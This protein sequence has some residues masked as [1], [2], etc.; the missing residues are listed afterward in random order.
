MSKEELD[1]LQVAALVHDI[2]IK[3]VESEFGSS[4]G[5]LQGQLGADIAR[6]ILSRL[7]YS[8]EEKEMYLL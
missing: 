5:K 3:K 7:N 1:T 8:K 6:K 2:G 4:N